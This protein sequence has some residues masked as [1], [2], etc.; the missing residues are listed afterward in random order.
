MA[1]ETRSD[2]VDRIKELVET[3]VR[4]DLGEIVEKVETRFEDDYEG[5]PSL[6]TDVVLN[7]TAPTNLG[8]RFSMTR[9]AVLNALRAIGE[10]RFLSL[11]QTPG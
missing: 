11:D 8:W 9:V 1:T 3:T 6:F 5:E 4:T 10:Q 2:Y 7:E